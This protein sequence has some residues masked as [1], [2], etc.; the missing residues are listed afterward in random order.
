MKDYKSVF[1][2]AP[3]PTR[4]LVL[5][6]IRDQQQLIHERKSDTEIH[7]LW[8]WP[9]CLEVQSCIP[10]PGKFRPKFSYKRKSW[11]Q[12]KRWWWHSLCTQCNFSNTLGVQ[13]WKKTVMGNIKAVLAQN[14]GK[15]CDEM[16]FYRS[17]VKWLRDTALDGPFPRVP[18]VNEE[19]KDADLT[20]CYVLAGGSGA[21][22]PRAVF[23]WGRNKLLQVHW[24]GKILNPQYTG[25]WL[26]LHS[27]SRRYR[28]SSGNID[29]TVC[30][31]YSEGLRH[32]FGCLLCVVCHVGNV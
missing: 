13:R 23:Q 21:S 20:V 12:S 2:I 18:R 14:M 1:A 17:R 22:F 7:F 15:S 4:A 10:S 30:C 11:L 9:S 3:H 24:T 5:T 16:N 8:K 28:W 27:L 6:L 19:K 29:M 26:C 32:Y 25:V 31:T